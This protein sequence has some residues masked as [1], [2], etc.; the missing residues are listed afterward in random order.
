MRE[1]GIETE[2]KRE[3]RLCV[4]QKGL[5]VPSLAFEDMCASLQNLC[6]VHEMP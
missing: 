4:G 6:G 3:Q 1:T 2:N 5:M